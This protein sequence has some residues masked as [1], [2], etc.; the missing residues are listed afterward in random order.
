MALYLRYRPN[1]FKSLV[2][3]TFVKETLSKA[4]ADK[5]TVW[6][7]LFCGPR[8]T[9][10]TSTARIFAKAVNCEQPD[11]W[12]PCN[13]CLICDSINSESLIDVIEIDAA[14]HTGVDN[15]REIIEKAQFR[16]TNCAFKIY[17][18]DE[19]HMLSKWAFNALL[20]ILEEPPEY[21]KFVLATTETHKVPETIIS[22]C[23]RFDM[24]NFSLDELK[25]RL[26]FIAKKEGITID[27]DSLNYI[28]KTASGWM[29]NAISLF[30]QLIHDSEIS[31]ERVITSLG[32][33]WEDVLEVF[34]NK[35]IDSDNS[36]VDDFHNF[37]SDGKNMKLFL[38]NF[39]II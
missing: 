39:F 10:K 5:K 1:D 32:I 11:N 30:E 8:W 19:V 36:I 3:Q 17:I 13:N 21:V 25:W 20:K 33:V 4:V 7:Y 23:Q 31:F 24:K 37:I 27:E 14:S 16:P 2:W 12:N 15:I 35:L 22:R 28:S 9:W 29:R 38:K 6:A 34:M 18:I 26:Q